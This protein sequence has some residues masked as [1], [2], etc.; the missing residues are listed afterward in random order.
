MSLILTGC[1]IL[2]VFVL[3][4]IVLLY[5]IELATQ[6]QMLDEVV[7]ILLCTNA[8]GNLFVLL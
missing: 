8:L 3:S 2:L 7:C 5:G 4:V 6:I 1:P